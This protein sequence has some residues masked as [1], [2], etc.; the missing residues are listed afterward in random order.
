M[1]GTLTR[2]DIVLD[3]MVRK[4]VSG[5]APRQVYLF[6][7]R[8]RGEENTDSDYDFLVVLQQSKSPGYRRAHEAFRMRFGLGVPKD[9]V[10][11]T[12][13]E[14]DRKKVVPA[15]LP[16]TVIREGVLLYESAGA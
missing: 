2:Q 5:L 15:S 4:L 10:V 1:T 3:E 8:A 12:V 7:S 11:L 9:V 13:E 16:A 14:F 6:G